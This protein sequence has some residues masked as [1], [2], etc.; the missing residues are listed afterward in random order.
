M[1]LEVKSAGQQPYVRR[2]Y[3]VSRTLPRRVGA[4]PA[5][6]VILAWCGLTA[7]L[8]LTNPAALGWIGIASNV[9]FLTI[10]SAFAVVFVHAGRGGQR[11]LAS[12]LGL[13]LS[14]GSLV[15]VSMLF[16]VP[17]AWTATRVAV[18]L[19]VETALISC[20]PRFFSVETASNVG[21]QSHTA[22]PESADTGTEHGPAS[23]SPAKYA[24]DNRPRRPS[25]IRAAR[26]RAHR[27]RRVAGR[28]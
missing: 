28:R 10:G 5:R 27:P 17:H 12:V 14:L 20:L 8:V 11:V 9:L 19:I 24:D 16:L 22:E 23:A 13:A 3:A 4:L 25:R 6:I 2:A 15:T 21:A 26:V 1:G 18:V 7:V